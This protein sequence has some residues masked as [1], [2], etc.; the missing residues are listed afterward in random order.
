MQEQ[1]K[2]A[3]EHKPSVDER[4][5]FIAVMNSYLGTIKHYKTYKFRKR[6]IKRHLSIKIF[7]GEAHRQG[8]RF[9]ENEPAAEI[10]SPAHQLTNSPTYQL[11]SLPTCQLTSFSLSTP[12]QHLSISPSPT[13]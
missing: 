2:I 3:R 8:Y 6:A 4:A 7:W 5:K 10:S 12:A 9:T 13:A 1:N 11:A